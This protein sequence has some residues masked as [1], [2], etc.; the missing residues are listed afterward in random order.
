MTRRFVQAGL[1]VIGGLLAAT[2]AAA[3]PSASTVFVSAAALAVIDESS[4]TAGRAFD[5]PPDGSSTVAGGA[6]GLGVHLTPRVSVRAEVNIA[7]R[8]KTETNLP[9]ILGGGSPAGIGTPFTVNQTYKTTRK[10]TPVFAL[11]A[12]HL[13]AGRLTVEV[14]G[15]LGIVHQTVTSSFESSISGPGLGGPFGGPGL[16]GTFLLPPTRNEFR[17][18]G[19]DA[20]AVAGADFAVAATN[21]LAVVPQVRAYVLNGGLSLRPGLGLRW[22]F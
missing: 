7:D 18:S 15:G 19:Y 22:T 4:N 6:I 12:Y 11:L 2:P 13:P 14:V 20:V 1:V 5:A 17:S 8:A 16:G 3:Q 10:S 9:S 21:H